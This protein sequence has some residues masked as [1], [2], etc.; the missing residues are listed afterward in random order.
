[1]NRA[2]CTRIAN[3]IAAND[4]RGACRV[5]DEILTTETGAHWARDLGKLKAFLLDGAPRFSIMAKDGNGKLPFLAFSSLP[6][7]NF[8]VGAGDCLKFCYSFKAWRYPAAFCR[9]AQNSALLQSD[10]GREH[11][12]NAID[13]FEPEF[14]AID[15]RLYVDGDFTGVADIA[16]WMETLTA[17]PWLITYGYSKSWQSF[18]DYKGI[19][20]SNYK[21]NLSSGSKYSDSV[22][23]KLKA[24]DYVRGEFV[25]VSIGASVK[26]TD[27]ADRAHQSTLRKAYGS[28]AYTCTGKCGDCTPIGHACGSDRFKGIDIIIAVH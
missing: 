18:I 27:H 13:K 7:A 23:D 5:I 20:P 17:R 25:A 8:C 9:Q 3:A 4:N 16:F 12:L 22:K 6:G 19:V 1:M 15:F 26:S 11:I 24:F 21:L 28:K 14:G 10:S 2:N